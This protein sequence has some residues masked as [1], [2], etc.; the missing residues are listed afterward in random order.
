MTIKILGYEV[1]FNDDT[2]WIN[3][4]WHNQAT[5]E[6]DAGAIARFSK[7]GIDIHGNNVCLDCKHKFTTPEDWDYFLTQ[8]KEI[9]GID[10][11][12]NLPQGY[13]PFEDDLI[14]YEKITKNSL[15]SYCPLDTVVVIG[16]GDA[17]ILRNDKV[18]YDG[19]KSTEYRKLAEFE[20]IAQVDPADWKLVLHGPLSSATWERRGSN[21]WVCIE[22]GS[23]FA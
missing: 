2:V 6:D 21:K 4:N 11:S 23:G 10:V 1:L 15:G 8:M 5:G 13:S 17:Q 14:L 20:A 7:R 9:Y 16:F 22:T 3:G 19:E 18:F 12:E